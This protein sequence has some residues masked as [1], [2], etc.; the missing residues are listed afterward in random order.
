ML[1]ELNAIF[2]SFSRRQETKPQKT[3]DITLDSRLRVLFQYQK[4]CGAWNAIA[5]GQFSDSFWL[6]LYYL[7]LELHPTVIRWENLGVEADRIF[8]FAQECEIAQFYDVLELSFRALAKTKNNLRLGRQLLGGGYQLPDEQELVQCMNTSFTSDN[9]PCRLSPIGL[10][11]DVISFSHPHFN[12]EMVTTWPQIYLAGEEVTHQE[13]VAPA[14]YILRDPYYQ[15]AE[16]AFRKALQAFRQGR[17]DD[18]LTQSHSAFERVLK[19]TCQKQGWHPKDNKVGPLVATFL[20]GSG[21]DACFKTPLMTTLNV[22]SNF[23]SA[24][25]G[26]TVRAVNL[27]MAQYVIT[28]AAAAIVL[29]V[30]EAQGVHE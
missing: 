2:T 10:R 4:F 5:S 16:E 11:P 1:K 19:L 24:H 20:Q 25:G 7:F 8:R 14:L 3:E 12:W 28:S 30:N 9:A 23:G 22:R 21:L 18:C 13:A 17:Y 15:P 6:Q 27:H 29:V 26:E